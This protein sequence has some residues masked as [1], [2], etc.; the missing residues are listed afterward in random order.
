MRLWG[1]ISEGKGIQSCKAVVKPE[2]W[3]RRLRQRLSSLCNKH[4]ETL[5]LA[6]LLTMTAISL[7]RLLALLL[8]L[9]YR[10]VV[11]LK[12]TRLIII[13]F[14]VLPAGLATM[15]LFSNFPIALRC[16]NIVTSLCLVTSTFSHTKIFLTLRR[17]ESQAQDHVQQPTIM[18]RS[19][20]DTRQWPTFFPLVWILPS[21]IMK[22]SP[23]FPPFQCWKQINIHEAFA[24]LVGGRGAGVQMKRV[25][26]FKHKI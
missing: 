22:G 7:D 26:S 9:R 12:R 10:D 16:R 11:T 18:D 4:N 20:W 14:R 2:F 1:E 21:P 17:H 23:P 15:R 5:A 3:S 13:T 8:M 6:S 25:F 24:T 19:R